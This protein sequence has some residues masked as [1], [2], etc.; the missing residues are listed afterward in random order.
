MK[1]EAILIALLFAFFGSYAQT[2]I[3]F[4]EVN[5][6]WVS[7]VLYEDPQ[8]KGGDYCYNSHI[9]TDGDTIINGLKYIK[10]KE[11]KVQRM[12]EPF[13]CRGVDTT[14]PVKVSLFGWLR[15]DSANKKV[16][17]KKRY[18]V[19][20][21]LLYDFNLHI[22]DTVPSTYL[23]YNNWPSNPDIVYSS[24]RSNIGGKDRNVYVYGSGSSSYHDSLVEGIGS[25]YGENGMNLILTGGAG[26]TGT[27][28]CMMVSGKKIFPPNGT[29]L[30]NTSINE[31]KLDRSEIN[32]YPNPA[33]EN[34]RIEFPVDIKIESVQLYDCTGR[35]AKSFMPNSEIY[36]V[37]N[38]ASGIYFLKM[39]TK[40]GIYSKKIVKK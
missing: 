7:R 5:V 27:F 14:I 20:D 4:P 2:Y 32:I 12:Y 25:F 39:Q 17:L 26:L 36:S 28:L 13:V 31:K 22:G 30:V 11:T 29:C 3:P 16:Y 8:N 38:L 9:E 21:T 35:L 34:F 24:K 33:K 6:E 23:F 18:M 37:E 40:I 15:N 10:L 1:R 19:N